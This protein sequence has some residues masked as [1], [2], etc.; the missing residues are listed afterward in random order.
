MCRRAPIA[1]RNGTTRKIWLI[2]AD[3]RSDAQLL[4]GGFVTASQ[5][6]YS[7]DGAQLAFLGS[8]E[9][10]ERAQIYVAPANG[11]TATRVTN[12]EGGVV[13]F[14]WSPD[15]RRFAIVSRVSKREDRNDP[16]SGVT[17][18]RNLHFAQDG[19]G[20]AQRPAL[21]R[22]RC[23]HR[24][25][26]RSPDH[27][28]RLRSHRARLVARRQVARVH[29]GSY[30][31]GGQRRPQHGRVHRV[32]RGRDVTQSVAACRSERVAGVFA[33]RQIDRLYRSDHRG[34]T[35]RHLCH[36][37]RRR[38]GGEPHRDLR[39]AHSAVRVDAE[40]HLLHCQHAGRSPALQAGRQREE[41]RR[42]FPRSRASRSRRSAWHAMARSR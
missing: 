7:L 23:R 29:L 35:E 14:V 19:R 38:R 42:R 3:G 34:R 41:G 20:L 36:A 28:R 26:S 18:V 1:S 30:R 37:D 12:V 10:N 24:D 16:L 33:G 2:A 4:S 13:S 40:R 25:W 9:Q 21:A 39:R 5:P 27:R 15:G 11:G 31:D 22:V 6:R 17:V 32:G 8:K